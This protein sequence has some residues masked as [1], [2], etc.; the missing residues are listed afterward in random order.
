MIY[1]EHIFTK[2][3]IKPKH[4]ILSTRSEYRMKKLHSLQKFVLNKYKKVYT[5]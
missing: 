5:A 3:V 2:L 1:T 4:G